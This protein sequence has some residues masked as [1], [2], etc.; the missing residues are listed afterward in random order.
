[1]AVRADY[2]AVEG[3]IGRLGTLQM[4]GI[5]VAE[6]DDAKKYGLDS[7]QYTVTLNAGSARSTLL[8]GAASGDGSL[9]AKDASRPMVFTVDGTLGRRPQE[10]RR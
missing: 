10:G 8:V 9:Y 2:G 5:T 1:M 4:K 7:P 6:M 3:L